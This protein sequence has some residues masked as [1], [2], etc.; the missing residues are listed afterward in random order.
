MNS[1]PKKPCTRGFSIEIAG[2]APGRGGEEVS[3]GVGHQP[4]DP[5]SGVRQTGH[6]SNAA[7]GVGG[8][9]GRVSVRR[10]VFQCDPT[11]GL[12]AGDRVF[13]SRR[14][15][16]ALSMGHGEHERRFRIEKHTRWRRGPHGNPTILVSTGVVQREGARHAAVAAGKQPHADEDLKAVADSQNGA[17]AGDELAKVVTQVVDELV[18]EDFSAGDVIAITEA[19]GDGEDLKL[20]EEPRLLDEAIDVRGL[21]GRASVSPGE[22]GFLVAVDAGGAENKDTESAAHGGSVV[23]PEAE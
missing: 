9:I 20:G 21:D 6:V 18:A 15:Y 2:R 16:L 22:G 7:I 17:A 19:A 14:K 12:E 11:L 4:Q 3:L 5:P 13:A 8:E 10:D 1:P 23:E